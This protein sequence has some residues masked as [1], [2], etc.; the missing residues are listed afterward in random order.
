MTISRSRLPDKFS[1]EYRD[2][3]VWRRMRGRWR[4][5]RQALESASYRRTNRVLRV[6]SERAIKAY[7]LS[8][9]AEFIP[10]EETFFPDPRWYF[11]EHDLQADLIE[12]YRHEYRRAI[13]VS[14]GLVDSH[15][16][17][18]SKHR[19][20]WRSLAR[21]RDAFPG[22]VQEEMTREFTESRS[23][24]LGGVAVGVATM[25]A[26]SV[27]T[28]LAASTIIMSRRDFEMKVRKRSGEVNRGKA[29]QVARTEN[30]VAVGHARDRVYHSDDLFEYYVWSSVVDTLTRHSHAEINGQRIRKGELFD[31]GL[32]YPGDPSGPPDE[33]NNCRCDYFAVPAEAEV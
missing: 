16:K 13:R 28:A 19:E 23:N 15:V 29:K 5:T 26:A 7:S 24:F 4:K 32:R 25:W 21:V 9:P 33:V 8:L 20:E 14:V 10:G 30:A 6:H 2:L 11:N 17:E 27:S 3:S 1:K 12:L 18:M 31:N 22:E